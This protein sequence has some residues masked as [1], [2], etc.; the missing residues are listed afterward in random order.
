ML[1]IIALLLETIVGFSMPLYIWCIGLV[2]SPGM[3]QGFFTGQAIEAG[4]MICAVIAGGFGICG[5]LQLVV[6]IIKPVSE[7]ASPEKLKAY[8][9]TGFVSITLAMYILGFDPYFFAPPAL[10]TMHFVYLSRDYLFE[11]S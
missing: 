11:N 7:I 5:I 9:A 6:K 8:I 3:F 10:V 1:R 2:F 4:V